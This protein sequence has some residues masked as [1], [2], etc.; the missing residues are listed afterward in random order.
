MPGFLLDTNVLSETRRRIPEPRVTDLL[1]ATPATQLFVSVLTLGE[2][3]KGIELK[4]RSDPIVAEQLWTWASSI[5][6]DFADH[7]LPVDARVGWRWGL[8]MAKSGAPAID[9]LIAATALEADLTLVTR[10]VADFAGTGVELFNPW[11]A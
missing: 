4:R 7:V 6:R 9:A 3:R 2:F 5:E 11:Q 1:A 10:D 8:I